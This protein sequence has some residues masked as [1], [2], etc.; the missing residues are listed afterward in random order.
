[1]KKRNDNTVSVMITDK[2]VPT[3]HDRR[4]GAELSLIKLHLT[5]MIK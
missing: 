4:Y 1:M 3:L 5:Y 2:S